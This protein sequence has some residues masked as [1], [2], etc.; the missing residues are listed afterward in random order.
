MLDNDENGVIMGEIE[1]NDQLDIDEWPND[2]DDY[3][4]SCGTYTGHGTCFECEEAWNQFYS[5]DIGD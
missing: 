4:Y 5:D 2:P 3:C 1:K